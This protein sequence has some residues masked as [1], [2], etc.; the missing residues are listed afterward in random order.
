[1]TLYATDPH[2]SE[3][4]PDPGTFTVKRSGSTNFPL[5]VFFHLSGTASNG[6]D[7][8]QLGNSVR[9]PAGA[10]NP[11]PASQNVLEFLQRRRHK[12]PAQPPPS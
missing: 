2:A 12:R 1:M 3:A 10:E 6:V 5:A 8:E 4:G 11:A 9:I 7:Y